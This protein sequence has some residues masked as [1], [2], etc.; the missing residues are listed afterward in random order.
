MTLQHFRDQSY[1]PGGLCMLISSRRSEMRSKTGPVGTEFTSGFTLVELVIVVLIV[2]ILAAIAIPSYRKYMIRSHRSAAESFMMEVANA[3][4]RFMVDNRSYAAD[5][6]TLGYPANVWPS[7]V[8]ANYTVATAPG[9]GTP[10]TFTVTATPLS[11]SS[12]AGDTEC[13]TLTLTSGGSKQASTG[14]TA[15]WK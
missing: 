9:T 8:S 3:Q 6:S 4:E 5:M 10:P 2:A 11:G 13:G 12:Q 14:S 7:D 1:G 15:C